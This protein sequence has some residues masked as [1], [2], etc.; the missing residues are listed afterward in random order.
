MQ[1]RPWDAT[2]SIVSA[3]VRRGNVFAKIPRRIDQ[4]HQ[5][6]NTKHQIISKFQIPMKMSRLLRARKA[7]WLEFCWCRVFGAWCFSFIPF[8]PLH[9]FF[10]MFS[11]LCA[12]A[13]SFD[14]AKFGAGRKVCVIRNQ[15]E[16]L[17]NEMATKPARTN[18]SEI[19]RFERACIRLVAEVAQAKLNHVPIMF[20]VND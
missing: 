5:T 6:P 13:Q 14:Q 4:K 18:I 1:R 16:A 3:K 10:G 11:C 8:C 15:V 12:S 2:A 17:S 20:C 7:G 19:A 9:E